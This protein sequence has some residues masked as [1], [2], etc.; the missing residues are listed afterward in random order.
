MQIVGII[1][2]FVPFFLNPKRQ[3]F[4]CRK[5]V[6]S[7][8][9]QAFSLF[10][11]GSLF[12]CLCF[13]I[14]H[15]ERQMNQLPWSVISPNHKCPP[16]QNASVWNLKKKQKKKPQET[17][18]KTHSKKKSVSKLLITFRLRSIIRYS[19]DW[20]ERVKPSLEKRTLVKAKLHLK[21]NL[22]EKVV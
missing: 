13:A 22:K 11:R 21:R 12:L 4:S 14:C 10:D 20:G 18:M 9:C 2:V 16:F 7:W 3:K 6:V 8:L 1:M 5:P 17:L 19:P 15:L